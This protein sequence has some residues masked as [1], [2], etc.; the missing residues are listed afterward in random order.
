MFNMVGYIWGTLCMSLKIMNKKKKRIVDMPRMCSNTY[1]I[2]S[3]RCMETSGADQIQQDQIDFL[4]FLPLQPFSPSKH[5]IFFS[6][7][8]IFRL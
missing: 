7:N 1:W 4:F 5:L 3:E 6:F 8:L 2:Q